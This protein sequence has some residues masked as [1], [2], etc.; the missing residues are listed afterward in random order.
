MRQNR[1]VEVLGALLLIIVGGIFLLQ[2][3]GIVP[4]FNDTL[5]GIIWSGLFLAGGLVFLAMYVQDRSQW[6]PLIPGG[7]L[8]G[9]GLTILLPIGLGLPGELS[10]VALFGCLALAFGVVYLR[11]PRQNWWAIIP[12]GAMVALAV[13]ILSTTILPGEAPAA[14]F[15]LGMGAIFAFLY[16]VEIDG[17]R[18]NWWTLIPAGA[19]FSLALVVIFSALGFES[20]AGS[21]LFL[22]MGLTFGVLY[23]MRGPG[24]P[25]QWAWIPGLA[26]LGMGLFILAVS[27]GMPYANLVWPV[28]LIGAGVVLLLATQRRLQ[29]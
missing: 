12:A 22:G 3:L 26:C 15:F 9:V 2:T 8:V 23:L 18:Y 13:L 24:R 27:G 21:A 14:V 20:L 28:I 19:L 10:A 5:W 16:F 4:D 6:W 11:Q 7:A 17:R 1:W 29:S 25:L